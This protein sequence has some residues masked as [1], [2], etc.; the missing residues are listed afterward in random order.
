[1]AD[2]Q[3]WFKL[4][5]YDFLLDG[6]VDDLPLEAQAIL[7]RM[8]CL[9]HIEKS[10]PAQPEEI[11]RKARIATEKVVEHFDKLRE[12]FEIRGG[13]MFSHRME[14]EKAKSEIA[15]SNG[16]KRGE[17]IRSAVRSADG[18]A[19]GSAD[20][21]TQSQSQNQK[22]VKSVGA[23][24]LPTLVQVSAYCAERGNL[25][26]PQ[27]WLDHYAAN[28]WKVGRNQMRDWRAAVRQWERN[29][30][31]AA[32]QSQRPTD[33]QFVGHCEEI[34]RSCPLKMCD[35]TGW[36]ADEKTRN[37]IYCRCSP[38]FKANAS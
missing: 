33:S 21:L 32:N 2:H 29:G 1:M 10:C 22:K 7:V 14:A 12:F 11:A 28:G 30:L 3:P 27:Q 23:F 37:V 26:N 17:Q 34:T 36:W 4:Y 9:C 15:R 20:C 18:S 25:V 31:S 35:G 16:K 6:K 24:A 8:W 19:S 13:R 38:L 5:G